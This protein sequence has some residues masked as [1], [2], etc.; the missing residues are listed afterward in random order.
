MSKKL[1]HQKSITHKNVKYTTCL[2][3]KSQ[4]QYRYNLVNVIFAPR[5]QR[6]SVA[7]LDSTGMDFFPP[8]IWQNINQITKKSADKS[9][10][11]YIE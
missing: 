8:I 7:H 6:T 9:K 10:T 4:L 11:L 1:T 3:S 5:C 2:Q